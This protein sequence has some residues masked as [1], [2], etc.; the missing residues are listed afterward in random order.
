MD[1]QL[2]ISELSRLFF[3]KSGF[4]SAGLWLQPE[5]REVLTN[6]R[7]SDA[8]QIKTLL[9]KL[10]GIKAAGGDLCSAFQHSELSIFTSFFF[11][12][13]CSVL[14]GDYLHLSRGNGINLQDR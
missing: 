12:P 5:S 1:L 6:C 3:L 9:K 10:A 14:T 11:S 2:F 13:M 7:G 8:M 4:M